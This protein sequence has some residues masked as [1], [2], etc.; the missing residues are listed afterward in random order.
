[1]GGHVDFACNGIAPYVSGMRAGELRGLVVSTRTRV[2]DA[3]EV[4]TASEVGMPDLELV[5]GWSALYGPPG[6][7]KDVIE[8]WAAALANARD[9]AE[10]NAQV[11]RRGSIPG[12]LS[13]EETR[14]FAEGQYKAYKALAAQL[15]VK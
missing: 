11:K 1:M 5:S 10:W 9:D 7:S 3:P 14:R 12:I 6:L 13:P 15:P 8:R 2:A 4:P